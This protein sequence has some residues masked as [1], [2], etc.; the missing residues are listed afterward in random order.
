MKDTLA[1]TVIACSFV[2]GAM[3]AD[4][5][6]GEAWTSAEILTS[7]DSDFDNNMSGAAWNP[8]SNTFW[9]C[10]NGGPS[11]F[12]A[13][14]EN[15]AGSF[16][17]AT[18]GAGTQAKF[19]LGSG[20]FEGLCQV[21][22]GE[23]AVYI[24]VE[25]VDQIREYDVSTYGAAVLGNQWDIE[26]HVPAYTGLGSEGITFVPNDWL[27]LQ[28]FADSDGNPYVATNGMDGLM[29]VAHQNGGRVYVF[30]LSSAGGAFHFVGA[31]KTSRSESS[32]LEFDRSTGLLYIWHNTGPNYLEVTELTSYLDGG[33]RRFTQLAEFVGPK[34]GNLEGI[35]IVPTGET[36]DWC[37]IVD[38][39]NQDGAALMW[40]KDFQHTNDFDA[41]GMPDSWE[42]A[43]LASTTNSDGSIDTDSDSF[44]DLNEYLAGTNPTNADSAL[45]L[46]G[47]SVGVA[48]DIA[49]AWQSAPDKSYSVLSSTNLHTGFDRVVTSGLPADPPTN[50]FT[51]RADSADAAF[52]R[53]RLDL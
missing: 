50:W 40:F 2:C 45:V 5:W 14:V 20:D 29:F 30:D 31:Y 42:L 28:S 37:L 48:G 11:A 39:D 32:G 49:V 1:T 3:A 12:W 23:A 33:E 13:L 34:G 15:G 35:A 43:Y 4:P 51:N 26:A 19:D 16:M 9:V 22:F 41:D 21:D 25:A 53:V 38:D 46:S 52:Y 7:L 36:N 17:I 24:M 18:N 6:P 8:E 47:V 27:A 44:T 10:C